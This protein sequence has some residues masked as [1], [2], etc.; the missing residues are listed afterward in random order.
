MSIKKTFFGVFLSALIIV[1]VLAYPVSASEDGSELTNQLTVSA[2]AGM[3]GYYSYNIETGKETFVP[4]PDEVSHQIIPAT[5]DFLEDSP[6]PRVIIG[7]DNRKIVKEPSGIMSTIC[8]I[9]S[10]MGPATSDINENVAVGTAWLINKDHLL[11][12]GHMLYN[13][14]YTNPDGAHYAQHTAVY[15]GSSGGNYSHYRKATTYEVGGDF[16]EHHKDPFSGYLAHYDDWGVITLSSSVNLSSY[17]GIYPVN[18]ASEMSGRNYYTAGYPEDLNEH[19]HAIWNKCD[20]YYTNGKIIADKRRFLDLV[21][22]DI[23][24]AGGQSGSPVYSS[25]GS[26]GICAEAIIVGDDS[27]YQENY[28]ILINDWLDYYIKEKFS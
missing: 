16:A 6:T 27:S 17:M 10:R 22:T 7:P 15:V 18:S 13:N 28:L 21:T 23:D 1:L 25:R 26:N 4:P 19:K 9:G 20:M 24:I 3:H 5:G 11:T 14:D 12:A 2:T 8:L